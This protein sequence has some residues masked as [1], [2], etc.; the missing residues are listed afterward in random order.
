MEGYEK[1]RAPPLSIVSKEWKKA[2]D[3]ICRASRGCEGV[4]NT[5]STMDYTE[6]ILP[7]TFA[8]L[9]TND[10]ILNG[11]SRIRLQDV[12]GGGRGGA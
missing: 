7:V 6:H 2:S 9:V 10:D 12:T 11:W 5:E 3:D 4:F 8:T 1:I